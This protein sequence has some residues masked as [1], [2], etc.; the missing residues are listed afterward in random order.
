MIINRII[1]TITLVVLICYCFTGCSEKIARNYPPYDFSNEDTGYSHEDA[2]DPEGLDPAL[3]LQIRK[4]YMQQWLD[5]YKEHYNDEDY[6]LFEDEIHLKDIW[7]IRYDGSYSGCKVVHM[8]S[9]KQNNDGGLDTVEIAGYIFKLLSSGQDLNVYKDS[10]FYTI[11]EAFDLGF[12]SKEDVYDIGM[13]LNPHDF[14]ENN[15]IP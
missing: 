4:D 5:G 15:P 12:I 6:K 13:K 3:V 2:K 1:F 9:T 14:E 7:I 10:R 8:G 11:G